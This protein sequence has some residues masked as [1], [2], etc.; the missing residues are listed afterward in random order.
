MAYLYEDTLLK[1]Q[2][3]E[4]S[5]ND[6]AGEEDYGGEDDD[7]DLVDEDEDDSEEE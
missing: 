3:G 5:G 2:D 6:V 4:F 1:N 7:D